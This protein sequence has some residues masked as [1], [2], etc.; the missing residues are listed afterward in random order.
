MLAV[1]QIFLILIIALFVQGCG[2]ATIQGQLFEWETLGKIDL[3]IIDVNSVPP[4]RI[5]S[6]QGEYNFTVPLGT[7]SLTA[8]QFVGGNLA[9]FSQETVV[10]EQEGSF[11]LDLVLKQATEQDILELKAMGIET[12]LNQGVGLPEW[13][14]PL[15]LAIVVLLVIGIALR[16]GVGKKEHLAE[17]EKE[18][19][20]DK[21]ATEV[22]DILKRSGN[23]LTQKELRD[24]CTSCG[25]A[26]ISLIIS[27]LESAGKVKKIK[28]GRGNIIVLK[29]A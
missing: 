8:M 6:E 12:E 1:K 9:R 3:A 15:G 18:M 25:E 21:Y 11:T 19:V 23:R 14:L 20:L 2:A 24:K 16:K 13:L 27:E 7:Y 10:V 4:Q 26:K 29:E 28:K 17:E 22:L 5:V